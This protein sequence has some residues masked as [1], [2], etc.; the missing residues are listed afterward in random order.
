MIRPPVVRVAAPT[1]EPE[2]QKPGFPLIATAAPVVVAGVLFAVTGS[3]FMLLMAVLGPVIALATLA[4]GRRQRRRSARA[5]AERF[6]AGLADAAER[7]AVAQRAERHRLAT[8]ATLDAAWATTG[9]PLVVAVTRGSAPSGVEVSGGGGAAE[10]A[11]LT[12][13]RA[14]A[15]SVPDAPL[16][17]VVENGF[18]VDGPAVLAAAV[19]RTLALRIAARL[20]PATMRCE[21]PPGERWVRRLPH[22]SAD[23]TAGRYRFVDGDV[24]TTICWAPNSMAGL[25]RVDAATADATT[26]AAA[27]QVA[28]R[29]AE[30]A[31]I[32]GLK[33]ASAG[34]PERVALADLLG[35]PGDA[36]GSKPGL[37][38]P[39]GLAA[40]GVAMVDLVADGPHAVV[41]G[42]T[43]A[44]K[45]ELLVSWVLGMAAGRSPAEVAFV[46][47]DFKG[48]A[49]F[50]PL[51]GLPHVLGTLSDL[52]AA[53]ARRAIQSLRAEVRRR[54]Q[55]L[56]A[57]GARAI[58]ELPA[59]DLA[60][61][62]V[63]VDEFAA[64]VSESPELH[65]LF[66]DLA[67][68]GRSLGVHLVL[69]TQRPAGVVRDAV[70]ANVAV[71]I[72]LRVADRADS[73]GLVGDD[74]AA[75]LPHHPR[76]R[77]VVVD[78]AG[79][80][81]TVQV[82]LATRADV[83]RITRETSGGPVLRPWHD[84]LPD[85]VAHDSL[86]PA[87]G[88]AFGLRDLPAQQEQPVATIEPRHGH[89]L[90]LGA[91]GAGTTTALETIAA[92]AGERARW[93]PT[94]PVE[95]WSVL[96]EQRRLAADSVLLL[97]DVDLVLSRCPPDHAPE[98]ADLLTRLLRD[99]PARGIRVV[100]A[101]RRLAGPV[102]AL[103]PQFGSR[104]LLRLGSREEHMLAGGEGA[105]FDPR[106]RPG[107]G[108]WEGAVVQVALPTPRP[109]VAIPP[110]PPTVVAVPRQGE[111]AVVAARPRELA[112]RWDASQIRV[113][114]LG[115][116]DE[117]DGVGELV[118][119]PGRTVLLGDPEAW[120]ADWATLSRARRDLAIVF[121]GCGTADLR[122]IARTR[123]APPPLAPGEVWLVEDGTVRRAVL[124]GD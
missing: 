113:R 51:E 55:T 106:A 82:A 63:I 88:I 71:R 122:A 58:D 70:L 120:Q 69:C 14:E 64:L 79:N 86:P 73:L 110:V 77:A 57:A 6:R 49:A 81:R 90:V 76:G 91:P 97:D 52:D 98:L 16:L 80:R 116:P 96:A 11:E 85:V 3:P 26:R 44:G 72:A 43:G 8:F 28:D 87:A 1:V 68:R 56:A 94:D 89:V 13:L 12:R 93:L 121:H 62:V 23:G 92:G 111:L 40:D 27:S 22:E 10:P 109:R 17:R 9:E 84:P 66:A 15:S 33:P 115:Q 38:A 39:L 32:A 75:R 101:A 20:S 67:A 118:V 48:G 61:L 105:E 24:E 124:A 123:E 112:D 74:A 7:V 30:T 46:L 34:L 25:A 4:D 36:R 104:L 103:A 47:V 5:A 19:A 21:A 100:A 35:S 117:G 95:L 108:I 65:A 31:R 119:D 37:R 78:G 60:R 50:A 83:E 18:A 45:S 59:G 114:V 53:L 54:E 99:G 107:A 102:H 41:A 2:A 29:L 42:T